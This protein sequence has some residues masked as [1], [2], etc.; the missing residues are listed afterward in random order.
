M[1]KSF[2]L[3]NSTEKGICEFLKVLLES[4]KVEGVFCL[5]KTNIDGAIVY[6]LIT[7]PI[8]LKDA[9]PLYPLMPVNAGKLLSRFT[10]NGE[11]K[12]PIIA[13][14]K[15][16]EMRGFVELIKREQGNLKNLYILSFTCGGVFPTKDSVSDNIE[17]NLS[18]YWNS[19]K[20]GEIFEGLRPTCKSCNEFSPYNA[21]FT[22]DLL[23]NKNIDSETTIFINSD[24]GEKL[25]KDINANFSNKEL[26]SKK[27][28]TIK[29]ARE[30]Q[31]QEIFKEIDSKMGGIDGLI[32][33]FGKCISCHGCSKV[34]PICY[35]T[36]CEFESPDAEY[37][38]SNYETELKKRGG[39]RVPPGTL[40]FHLGRMSHIGISCVACGA[41]DDVCPVDI[42]IAV[43]FKRVSESIQDMFN[44]VPGKDLEEKLPLITFEKDEFTEYEG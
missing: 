16:C 17:K 8:E 19:A 34:C 41:C 26:D 38:P 27:L 4:K 35:C 42:P 30:K 40:Y 31:R 1:T 24:R 14:V 2:K 9:V 15:P 22:I 43:I 7:D 25:C 37:D 11:T 20:K 23:G 10:I 12:K 29:D 6:S 28:K 18:K 32:E 36:L 39:V 3:G 13:V 5:K 33:I 44:Y 21:D